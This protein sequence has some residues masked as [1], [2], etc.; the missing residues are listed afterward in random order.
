MDKARK[1]RKN[2]DSYIQ[3]VIT[4]VKHKRNGE[5]KAALNIL[6][7]SVSGENI[8]DR[9]RATKSLENILGKLEVSLH[10]TILHR[11]SVL[12]Y[13][14]KDSIAEEPNIVTEQFFVISPDQKH[15]HH[16]THCV[17]NLVSEYLKSINCEI[18]VIHEFTDGCSSQY[19]SRHCMGEILFLLDF[20]Y[21]KIGNYFETSHA[22]GP[23]DAAGG[24]IK[25]QADLAVIRNTLCDTKFK[26]TYLI[27]CR[28]ICP[29][30]R[31]F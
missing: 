31:L 10:V 25:K 18:L 21:A 13:D 19:K 26:T 14:G 11:H 23:Q 22:R 27:T 29:H 20:G 6:T 8:S 16:Y 17:Q 28:V 4:S 3:D 12:E 9:K 7:S 24:F 5:A 2:G 30:G 15:D 1:R